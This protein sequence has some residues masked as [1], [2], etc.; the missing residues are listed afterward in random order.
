V[1]E[2][3]VL[4]GYIQLCARSNHLRNK[5]VSASFYLLPGH[6]LALSRGNL[7]SS[8]SYSLPFLPV[9]WLASSDLA[10]MLLYMT[11]FML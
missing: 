3:A 5:C 9:T 2:L 11:S 8:L 10:T 4:I 7:V 6:C 1:T